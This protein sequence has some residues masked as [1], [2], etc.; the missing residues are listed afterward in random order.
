[1]VNT[2][3]SRVADSRTA[4][5]SVV[6][7]G[8]TLVSR[9]TGL[10]RVIVIG[11]VLGPTYLANA[12]ITTNLLPN[13]TY[14][15]IAGQALASVVVPAVVRAIARGGAERAVKLLGQVS[16]LLL[17]AAGAIA[18]L[19][20]LTS[21]VLASL[22]TF[23]VANP[24]LQAQAQHITTLLILLV[25]P[26]VVL[27]TVAALGAAAQQARERFALAAAAP[28][29]E[30]VLLTGTVLVAGATWGTGV[31][32]NQAPIE[33]LVTLG[34]GSTLAVAVH[35]GLQ[36]F[37]AA[38]VGLP[39]RPAVRRK[40]APEALEIARRLRNSVSVPAAPALSSFALLT[41]AATVPGGVVVVQ[42]AYMVYLL[43]TALGARAVAT[44]VLPRMSAAAE[45]HDVAAFASAWRLALA[46]STSA[47]LPLCLL[48]GVLAR[49]VAELLANGELRSA[50][51]IDQL[52]ACLTVIAVAQ[53]AAGVHEIGRQA[54]FARINI[55]GP[56]QA[57]LT[58]LTV[59]L[60]CAATSLLATAGTPRLLVLCTALLVGE[61]AGAGTVITKLRAAIRP[62]KLVDGARI[63]CA[64]TS[65]AAML[66][67]VAGGWWLLDSSAVGQVAT[68]AVLAGCGLLALA[69]YAAVLRANARTRIGHSS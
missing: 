41:L 45:R 37:G 38:R 47:S 11:A 9:T 43:P 57:S 51:L 63:A 20:A 53:I 18:A 23:G 44:A 56:R 19:V 62:E 33:L 8:W 25:T 55:R 30:N 65:T 29:V 64:A 50:L 24:G 4:R 39:L 46:Y 66:P 1:M 34:I 36:L 15:V 2:R 27:Y 68:F 26:Q 49:P 40:N 42:T 14:S 17:V 16:G 28:A 3:P 6:V 52:A 58:S 54:L 31:E 60:M 67:V 13:L 21:P 48:L 61:L 12:F 59:T 5:R 7:A 35:A 22:M 69:I 32:V 10:F